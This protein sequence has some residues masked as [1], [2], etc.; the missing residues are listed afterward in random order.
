[1]RNMERLLKELIPPNNYQCRNGF[2]NEHIILSLSENEKVEVE[3]NLIELLGETND[4]LIGETLAIM[5]STDSLPTMK[6]RLDAVEGSSE[7]II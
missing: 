6:Q 7:K 1:M 5:N 2:S 4:E 3:R